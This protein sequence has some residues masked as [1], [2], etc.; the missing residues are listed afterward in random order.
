MDNFCPRC[1]AQDAKLKVPLP[2]S[3]VL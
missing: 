2:S 3:T 1:K